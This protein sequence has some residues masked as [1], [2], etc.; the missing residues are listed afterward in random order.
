MPFDDGAGSPAAQKHTAGKLRLILADDH[1]LV[2]EGLR[3]IIENQDDMEVIGEARDGIE[4]VRLVN[5]RRPDI[6]LVDVSMPGMSGVDVTRT[7]RTSVPETRAIAVTRHRES[8]YL[9]ALLDA[10][11]CGYVLKQSPSS[12]LL[13][14]I[15][16]VAAGIAYVDAALRPKESPVVS[17]G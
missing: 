3:R 10:G 1:D 11:A 13:R 9:T 2:R 7:L 15:R 8:R 4:A 12:E 6:L 16:S 14:A 17:P 5:E